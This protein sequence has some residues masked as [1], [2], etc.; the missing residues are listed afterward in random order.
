MPR[1]VARS[2]AASALVLAFALSAAPALAG[3]PAQHVSIDATQNDPVVCAGGTYTIVSGTLDVTFRFGSSISGN[4]TDRQTWTARNVVVEDEANTQYD[5]VGTIHV[6]ATSN[7]TT[8]GSQ[9][10][11]MWKL[12]IVG[13][14]DSVNLVLRFSPSGEF[15]SFGPG[16]CSP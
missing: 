11:F 12:Q 5:A 8:G 4:T 3:N 2:A 14:A 9:G 6:G 1:Q 16:T 10:V 15:S 13:T 7:A